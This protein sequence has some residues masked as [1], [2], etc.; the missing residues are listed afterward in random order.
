MLH[1]YPDGIERELGYALHL[2][3]D[4]LYTFNRANT[5]ESL[6]SFHFTFHWKRLALGPYNLV[7]WRDRDSDL[8][9]MT[10]VR[11]DSST[12]GSANGKRTSNKAFGKTGNNPQA[13]GACN[14]RNEGRCHGSCRLKHARKTCVGAHP[15]MEHGQPT[16]DS[17]SVP[18]RAGAP[19]Q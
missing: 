7:G 9:Q 3:T 2:Y 10:L 1:F 5:P 15:A 18:V 6:K 11:R 17:N 8:Q 14:N 4:L 12:A 13:A 16:S 19:K